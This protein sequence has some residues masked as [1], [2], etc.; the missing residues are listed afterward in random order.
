MMPAAPHEHPMDAWIGRFALIEAMS[1]YVYIMI[2]SIMHGTRPRLPSFGVQ[3]GS[4][5]AGLFRE[6]TCPP[7]D[8]PFIEFDEQF[9]IEIADDSAKE[10][11]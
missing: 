4:K 10:H 1:L 2:T 8:E 6:N 9:H 5:D 3:L 7:I 11:G